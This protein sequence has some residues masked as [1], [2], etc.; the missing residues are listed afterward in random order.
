MTDYKAEAIT[1]NNEL[2]TALDGQLI[3]CKL[4]RDVSPPKAYKLSGPDIESRIHKI[5]D[6]ISRVEA[7]KQ[8]LKEE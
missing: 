8:K 2:L 7:R 3:L 4:L 1:I 6:Q 5:E